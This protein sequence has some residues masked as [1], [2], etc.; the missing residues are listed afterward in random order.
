MRIIKETR[1]RLRGDRAGYVGKYVGRLKAVSLGCFTAK[2][3][4]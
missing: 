3:H 2:F 1:T 4:T